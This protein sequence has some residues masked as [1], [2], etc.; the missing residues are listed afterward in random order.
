MKND[1]PFPKTQKANNIKKN[2]SDYIHALID[3][4]FSVAEQFIAC[5]HP[6]ENSYSPSIQRTDCNHVI[7][8]SFW[9][10]AI[11]YQFLPS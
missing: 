10:N 5:L 8:D 6:C 9:V 11:F 7:S 2:N 3:C 4:L 1:L